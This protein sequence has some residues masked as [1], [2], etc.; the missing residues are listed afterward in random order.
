MGKPGS[1]CRVYVGIPSYP[2]RITNASRGELN[3]S[4]PLSVKT[5][6][7]SIH[8]P[9]P[10]HITDYRL[11]SRMIERPSDFCSNAGGFCPDGGLPSGW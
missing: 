1:R 10:H 3:H 5:Q 7:L 2:P 11:L 6:Y 9:D 8:H 4:I